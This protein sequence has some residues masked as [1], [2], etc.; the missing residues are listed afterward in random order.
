M[1]FPPFIVPRAEGLYVSLADLESRVP[2][3]EFIAQVFESGSRFVDLDYACMHHLLYKGEQEEIARL[4]QHFQKAGKPP[5]LRLASDVVP[6][7]YDRQRYYRSVR[8]IES[9]RAAE[10]AFEP[11]VIAPPADVPDFVAASERIAL[12]LDEFIAAMWKIHVRFGLDVEAIRRALASNTKQSVVIAHRLSPVEGQDA[13]VEELTSLHRDNTPKH[14]PDGRVDLH[15]FENRFPQVARNT[16]LI[17]KIPCVPGKKGWD[18]SGGELLPK[19]PVDI[20]IVRRAGSG[21]R[22]E[23]NAEGEFVVTEAGGF[24]QFNAT[25]KAFSIT[26]KIINHQ[27]VSLR[28]TGNLVLSGDE[29]EEHGEVEELARVEGKNMSFLADVFG[30]IVSHGG[31]VTLGRN[32]SSGSIT[33]PGGTVRVEGSASRATIEAVDGE[34]T[35]RHAEGCLIV[36]RKVT[37]GEAIL[38]DIVAD[39]IVIDVAEGSALAAR[40]V[41]VGTAKA[42]HDTETMVSVSV[43][44]LFAVADQLEQLKR[45]YTQHQQAMNTKLAEIEAISSEPDLKNYAILAGKLRSGEL[46]MTPQQEANWQKLLSRVTPVLQRLKTHNDELNLV[47]GASKNLENRIEGLARRSREVASNIGCIIHSVNGETVIRTLTAHLDAPPLHAIPKRELRARL[48]EADG[49][50]EVLFNASHGNFEWSYAAK[51]AAALSPGGAC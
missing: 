3:H 32:L 23:C 48:R 21:T 2:F 5:M 17:R 51:G 39:E 46:T 28:T 36:G 4:L 22:V 15:Q 24:L 29:Y 35:L 45:S 27:G 14:L 11:V 50:C 49:Q 20:D 41:K 10:Y 1:A 30:D 6:F 13:S 42:W 43:P 40:R 8:M 7:P 34:V 47:R 37:I 18:I 38:C 9:G 33:N 12:D 25:T 19:T 16:R 26:D 44:D 31:R